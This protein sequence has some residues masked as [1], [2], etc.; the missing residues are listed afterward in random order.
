MKT[1]IDTSSAGYA[2]NRAAMLERVADLAVQHRA[3]VEAG[4]ER[5]ID[6]HHRRGKLTA[7]LAQHVGRNRPVRGTSTYISADILEAR[8]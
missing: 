4:G 7:H 1:T 8:P 2:A 3:A 6:R 5:N